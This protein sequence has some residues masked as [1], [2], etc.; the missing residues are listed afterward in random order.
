MLGAGRRKT[1][2]PARY[3]SGAEYL[4][5]RANRPEQPTTTTTTPTRTRLPSSTPKTQ[6]ET[7][8]EAEILSVSRDLELLH[9]E[10]ELGS[11]Q[12]ENTRRAPLP[13]NLVVTQDGGAQGGEAQRIQRTRTTL[14]AGFVP[15]AFAAQDGGPRTVNN[16]V[17]SRGGLAAPSGT[18]AYPTAKEVRALHRLY[19]PEVAPDARQ[20]QLGY[21]SYPQAPRTNAP[22]PHPE[23]DRRWDDGH[24]QGF[25]KIDSSITMVQVSELKAEYLRR[26]EPKSATKPAVP[27]PATQSARNET[28][29]F[30]FKY[31]NGNCPFSSGHTAPSGQPL[32]HVCKFC[33]R[34]RPEVDG[35]HPATDC[36]Y[37]SKE[38]R[39]AYAATRQPRHQHHHQHS[40]TTPRIQLLA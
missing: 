18:D 16:G 31:Q 20:T 38:A 4:L 37:K 35:H 34:Y 17:P 40:H 1:R 26:P 21:G 7:E 28:S 8:L 6:A 36:P 27:A 9:L 10:L 19:G 2:P 30:C 33:S 24:A 39:E 25:A 12:R 23:Y 3:T 13:P 15:G 11:Q 14:A 5:P 32:S 22:P 29:G